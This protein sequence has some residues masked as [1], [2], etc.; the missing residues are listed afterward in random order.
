VRTVFQNSREKIA[1]TTVW[2][3]FMGGWVPGLLDRDRAAATMGALCAFF[4]VFSHRAA[5][6]WAIILG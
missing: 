1:R 2:E 3:A 4:P 6:I 5:C